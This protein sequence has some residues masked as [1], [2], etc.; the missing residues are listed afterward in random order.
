VSARPQTPSQTIG[1]FFHDALMRDGVDD[2]DPDG[3]AGAPIV[4]TGTVVDGVGDVVDDA[5]VELWQSDGAGRYRHPA[6][7]RSGDVPSSFIGFGRLATAADGTFRARTV[8]PGTVPG[9]EGTVQAPHLNVHVFARGLLDKLATRI[10]FE[11]HA[12]NAHDPVLQS[13]PAPRR[14]TLVA[15][16]DGEEDGRARYRFDVVLQGPGETVFFDA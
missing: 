9:R 15:R 13:V 12:A 10:Y 8:M 5:M 14:D 16:P 3:E 11:G 2:L 6:D 4:V 1:P 7:G